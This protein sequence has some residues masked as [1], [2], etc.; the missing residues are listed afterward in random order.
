MG[1]RNYRP[2]DRVPQS[3]IFRVEHGPHRL[4]HLAT[5]VG[6][7]RFPV[8]RQCGRSVRFSLIRPVKTSQ[9]LPFRSNS[10]LEEYRILG[11]EP[12]QAG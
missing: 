3:G 5:L 2:G 12:L 8:C 4:M 1:D 11:P 7:S 6:S 9:V 10:L